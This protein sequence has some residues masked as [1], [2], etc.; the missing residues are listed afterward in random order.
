MS[1]SKKKAKAGFKEIIAYEKS[2]M[3]P[4]NFAMAYIITP[5]Y[6]LIALFL[7]CAFAVLMHIDG[8]QYWSH[9][10]VCLGVLVVLTIALVIST[11]IVRKQAIKAELLRYHFDTS[12]EEPREQYDYSSGDLS[13]VFDKS[14][15]HVNDK[16]FYYNR[17]SKTLVI[18]NDCK[19]IDLFF[20]FALSEEHYLML[21]VDPTALKMLECFQIRLDNQD[22]LEAI[23]SNP[24][25][26][27]ER[28]YS[29]GD[30]L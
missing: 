2:K 18:K 20:R 1:I 21:Y 4:L 6:G 5:I 22:Q 23:L 30:K 26:A 14:G 12:K 19:R 13:L 10:M 17:L 3:L 16:L 11:A 8:E 24:Q 25:K 9:A 28:I 27:F 15:L 7:I 29:R